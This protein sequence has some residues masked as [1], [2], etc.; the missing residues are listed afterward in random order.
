MNYTT[1]ITSTFLKLYL[2]NYYVLRQQNSNIYFLYKLQ[3]TS[4]LNDKALCVKVPC[5]LNLKYTVY[6]VFK[7]TMYISYLNNNVHII[8]KLHILSY[9]NCVQPKII[10]T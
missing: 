10:K 3:H 7:L 1:I 8:F 6:F 2:L 5:T 9:C 4:C